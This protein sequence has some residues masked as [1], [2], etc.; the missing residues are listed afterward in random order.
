MAVRPAPVTGPLTLFFLLLGV[1]AALV[2]L[3]AGAASAATLVA[4]TSLSLSAVVMATLVAADH[5]SRT[6][7]TSM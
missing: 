7:T 5:R 1:Q 6:D 2:S 3:I 4:A